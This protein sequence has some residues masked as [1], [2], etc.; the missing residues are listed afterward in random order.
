MYKYEKTGLYMH[1]RG[2]C[3]TGRPLAPS[4]A[5]RDRLEMAVGAGSPVGADLRRALLRAFP[6]GS[7]KNV[8]QG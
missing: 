1:Y 6:V 4:R 8:G 5:R 2:P 7:E 3:D